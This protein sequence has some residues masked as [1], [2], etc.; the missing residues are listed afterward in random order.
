MSAIT[1]HDY[2][3]RREFARWSLAGAIVLAVHFG[4]AAS[5]LMLRNT[6]PDGMPLAPAVIIDLAPLPVA[7]A[8]D[9]DI[10]VGPQMQE[11]LVPPEPKPQE[12]LEKLEPPPPAENPIVATPEPT[13]K[14]EPKPELKPKAPRT[15]AAPRSPIH[16]GTVAAA[17]A[18]GSSMSS[19]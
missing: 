1:L 13:S 9:L 2:D 14:V 10:A 3:E 8:S 18:P 6:A 17:P 16:T 12:Q 7:P 15:T 5:Y 4:L 11:S 19:F